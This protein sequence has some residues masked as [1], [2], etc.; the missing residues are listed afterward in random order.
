MSNNTPS[1]DDYLKSLQIGYKNYK[2]DLNKTG[3]DY[4]DEYISKPP[5]TVG[6]RNTRKG[7]AF[8]NYQNLIDLVGSD[9]HKD[10]KMKKAFMSPAA[11][12]AW[13][14]NE[15]H[16]SRK[17]WTS[18]NIDLDNDG[19][20][21]FLVRDGKGNLIGV[22]GYYMTQSKYPERYAFN[23]TVNRDQKSKKPLENYDQW[24][25]RIMGD[26]DTLYNRQNL[27]IN[28]SNNFEQSTF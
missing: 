6:L 12:S 26:R 17:K 5:R 24:K 8:D 28:Y 19:K 15:N 21:E 20:T 22:N 11:F 27:D 1:Y 9:K 10:I 18:D 25:D 2:D 7:Y 3:F 4:K 14:S 16:P 13:Q 23:E